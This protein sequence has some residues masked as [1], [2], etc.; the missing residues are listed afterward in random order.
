[1]LTDLNGNVT[2]KGR[3][4][5]RERFAKTFAEHPQNKAW[6]VSRIALSSSITKSAS[7]HPGEANSRLSLCTLSATDSSRVSLWDAVT[8]RRREQRPCEQT[9]QWR[10]RSV[11]DTRVS[12]K[13]MAGCRRNASFVSSLTCMRAKTC[14]HCDRLWSDSALVC[15]S[16]STTS[17]CM[18]ASSARKRFCIANDTPSS[19]IA[20]RRWRTRRL[21]SR[22]CTPMPVC[23]VAMSRPV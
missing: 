14:D 3:A 9:Q 17:R 1:M 7:D 22:V 5:F 21:K 15:S 8:E 13:P 20:V 4:A 6:S 16:Y 2:L 18:G 11:P 10:S 12:I 19:L 23:D